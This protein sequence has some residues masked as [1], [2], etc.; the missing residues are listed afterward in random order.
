[1]LRKRSCE[2]PPGRFLRS[3]FWGADRMAKGHYTWV[4]GLLFTTARQAAVGLPAKSKA[5]ALSVLDR[6]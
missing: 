6:E 4:A 1:M 2:A 5:F 3:A